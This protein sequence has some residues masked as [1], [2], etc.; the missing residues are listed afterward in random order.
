M[1]DYTVKLKESG[2]K[3]WKA[4]KQ[5]YHEKHIEEAPAGIPVGASVQALLPDGTFAGKGYYNSNS[6][7]SLRLLTFEEEPIDREFWHRRLS[8]A[9]DYRLCFYH[10][11]DSFRLIFGDSDRVPG[12]I[13]DKFSDVIV[14]QITT[15]G[16]ELCKEDILDALEGLFYPKAIVLAC[17]SLPRKKEGLELY[18]DVVR[19]SVTGP[20]LAD[21]DGIGH[22]VDVLNGHKTG[23]FLDHRCNRQ[24]AAEFSKDRDVLDMFCFTGAFAMR[25]AFAGATLVTAVDIHEPSIETG[26]LTAKHHQRSDQVNF[27]RAEAFD[28]LAN[29]EQKW[30]TIFLDPPSFVRGSKRARRNLSNYRKINAFAMNCLKPEGILITSCCSFH[31]SRKDYL[32]V[33]ESAL[34]TS[35]RSAKIFRT[36]YQSPDHPA[37]PGVDGTD[38]LK[39]F[40]LKMEN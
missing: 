5:T 4:Q 39:C 8:K 25:A 35:G 17:D 12:L 22:L 34:E 23:F 19:G 27:V 15:A 20:V 24:M 21:I 16:I 1:P 36:G 11:N 38:Y 14:V 33:I 3:L 10:T 40:F 9:L 2:V 13:I 28:Y 30:D 31:V 26:V 32:E 7:L 6:R 18:R 37:I 29:T